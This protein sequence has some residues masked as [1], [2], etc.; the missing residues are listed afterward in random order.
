[1]VCFRHGLCVNSLN[2]VIYAGII[3][4]TCAALTI[5]NGADTPSSVAVYG[6]S[7]TITCNAGYQI[8]GAGTL[9]CIQTTPNGAGGWDAALPTC[10][11]GMQ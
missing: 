10:T 6:A 3:V 1:M 11:A 7:A 4:V 5:T 2:A 9:N 8:S